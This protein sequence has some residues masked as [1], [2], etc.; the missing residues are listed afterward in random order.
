MT[1]LLIILPVLV[2]IAALL[3]PIRVRVQVGPEGG[4][5]I[6]RYLWIRRRR[7]LGPFAERLGAYGLHRLEMLRDFAMP[8]DRRPAVTRDG[9]ETVE[10]DWSLIWANRP[11]WRRVVQVIFRMIWRILRSWTVE[12]GRADVRFGLGDPAYTGMATGYLHAFWPAIGTFLPRW[13]VSFQPDFSRPVFAMNADIRLR[14]IPIVPVWHF[15]HAVGSLPWGGL[16]KMRRAW[17]S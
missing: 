11:V 2:L 9:R 17:S 6:V 14:L 8:R 12:E 13:T 1:T 5:V 15:L 4:F 3:V 10:T 16:W 7:D